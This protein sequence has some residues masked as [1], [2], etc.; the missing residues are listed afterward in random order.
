MGRNPRETRA[1]YRAAR[2]AGVRFTLAA[3]CF[4]IALHLTA[5]CAGTVRFPT[6]PLAV[7]PAETGLV[8]AYDTDGNKQP[9][10]FTTED[11][12]G[13]IVRI[14]Y[15]LNADGQP[16]SF[17][18]LDD[19]D[20]TQCRHV[21]FILDG[22]G[23]ETIE[24]FQRE[25]GL[26]LFHPPGRV[27][28]TFPAMTDLALADVFQSV[29]CSA[30]EVVYF[31]HKVNRIVG[32]DADYLSLVN[33]DWVHCTDYRAATIVDPLAYLFPSHFF[34]QEMGDFLKLFDQRDRPRLVAYFVSTA[35]FSTKEL[36]DGQLKILRR[37]DQ[38]SEQLV[39][40]TRGL[41]KITVLSD[42]GH[43]LVRCK[44]IDF[45]KFLREKGW[46]VR[47]RLGGPRDVVPVEYGLVTYASF[48]VRDRAALAATLLENEGVD[49]VAY[50]DGAAVTVETADGK[51]L[52]ERRGNRYRYRPVKGDP[53][54]LLPVIEK[55]KEGASASAPAVF[56]E[57]GFADDRD[58]LRM[59]FTHVY[60]DALDRLWRSYHG[61]TE[62]VP[63]VI[64]SL[65]AGYSSGLA[66]RA[67]RF[68][69][70]AST[71]GDL[72]RKNSTAFVISTT[73][74]IA[75]RWPYLRARDMPE[76]LSEVTGRPWP[77][78]RKGNGQ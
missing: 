45:G 65:K 2:I 50:D 25:G 16:D 75:P 7:H 47:D 12:A 52:I 57:E 37:I 67:T 10:Y 22:I 74:P 63:D 68:P 29:R 59:T 71:H 8:K 15:D 35:G 23:H 41:V 53:L 70:G 46:N 49:V 28:S 33:E 77:P 40:K 44:W 39:W 27:M 69:E 58:W 5:G 19:I 43:A 38:I 36:L 56:D 73:C 6:A 30:N 78:P 26:R 51:A 60:P 17:V 34:D 61:Q 64:V 48:A 1:P 9:D 42:H 20:V 54:Q 66:S 31:D 4:I 18:D 62:N 24:A 14:A 13:R 55:A 3:G 72:A 32:G 76:V 21:V 11:A